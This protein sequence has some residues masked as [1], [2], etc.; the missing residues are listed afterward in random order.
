MSAIAKCKF[1]HKNKLVL[2]VR[3][4]EHDDTTTNEEEKRAKRYK[5]YL[6]Q[7]LEH[8]SIS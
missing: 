2:A 1:K 6:T 7:G 8:K 4:Q 3:R 5:G